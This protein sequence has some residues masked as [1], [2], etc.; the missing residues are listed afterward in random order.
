MSEGNIVISGGEKQVKGEESLTVDVKIVVTKKQIAELLC[1]GFEGGI[2]YWCPRQPFKFK[3]PKDPVRYM[4]AG[5][6]W[7]MYDLP[8]QKGGEVKFRADD[9]MD[10]KT[11]ILNLETVSKGLQVMAGKHPRHFGNFINDNYDAE[12]GDVFIQCCVFGDTVY[13]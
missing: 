4:D 9:D 10:N 8:L 1:T 7:D 3:R 2:S 11:L 12:T 5:R 13:G 6:L